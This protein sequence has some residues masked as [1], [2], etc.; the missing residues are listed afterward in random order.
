MVNA[1]KSDEKSQPA[2]ENV[3]SGTMRA[4]RQN[5][6]GSD[7]YPVTRPDAP[8]DAE[9]QSFDGGDG[10]HLTHAVRN[11]MKV[12]FR[13]DLEGAHEGIDISSPQLDSGTSR[14]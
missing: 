3:G 2:L 13:R 4:A 10:E 8:K 12:V 1:R 11:P 6:V 14:T 7:V 5:E 9:V